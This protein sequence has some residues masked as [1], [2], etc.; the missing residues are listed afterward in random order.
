MAPDFNKFAA[1]GNR[2]LKEL[3]R[4]LGYP[5]DTAKAGRVLRSTLHALRRVLTLEESIQLLAQ[6]PMFLKA[7]YV[8][9][10]TSKKKPKK[11][12]HLADFYNEIRKIDKQTAQYDFHKEEDMDKALKVVF[13]ALHKYV[14]RGELEDIRAVLPKDLKPMIN[15]VLMTQD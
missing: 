1:D 10:W 11:I 5:E 9:S 2:F 3:A 14:S 6:L 4:E 13:M 12:K 15:N 7:V 8:E